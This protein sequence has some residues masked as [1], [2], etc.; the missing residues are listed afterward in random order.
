M[1]KILHILSAP[2]RRLILLL[3]KAGTVETE[4]DVMIRRKGDSTSTEIAVIHGHL[5][6]LAEAGYIEWDRTNGEVSK[7]PCFDEIEPFLEM[8]EKHADELPP[9]W[10]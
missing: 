7:G 6:K 10:P 2:H 5:P 1:D 9:D 8:I 3:L 4:T